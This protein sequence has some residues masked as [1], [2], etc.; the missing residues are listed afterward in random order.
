MGAAAFVHPDWDEQNGSAA[1]GFEVGTREVIDVGSASAAEELPL[2]IQLQA[3][4]QTGLLGCTGNVFRWNPNRTLRFRV[5]ED[6]DVAPFTREL[7]PTRIFTSFLVE[8]ET[9]AI[10]VRPN[11]RLTIDVWMRASANATGAQDL[12]GNQCRG[13]YALFYFQEPPEPLGIQVRL[14][15]DPALTLTPRSGIAYLPVPEPAGGAVVATLALL[16]VA[17]RRQ[18]GG[19]RAPSRAGQPLQRSHTVPVRRPAPKPAGKSSFA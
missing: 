12:Q 3:L 1:F 5:T 6:S 17:L 10:S 16:A 14:S 11:S 15:A 8:R 4:G 18:H 13:A 19:R 9:Y 2:E 7:V